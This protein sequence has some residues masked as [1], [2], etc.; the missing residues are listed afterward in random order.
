MIQPINTSFEHY[1][2]FYENNFQILSDEKTLI[3]VKHKENNDLIIMED[4]QNNDPDYQP[5]EFHGNQNKINVILKCETK[6]IILAGDNDGRVIQ[7]NMQNAQI[8]KNYGNLGVGGVLSAVMLD[9]IA[10]FGGFDDLRVIQLNQQKVFENPI[11]TALNGIYSMVFCLIKNEDLTKQPKIILSCAG[12]RSENEMEKNDLFDITK[13]I[14]KFNHKIPKTLVFSSKSDEPTFKS[15]MQ[16]KRLTQEMRKKAEKQ[17]EVKRSLAIEK[18][19]FLEIIRKEKNA[20]EWDGDESNLKVN[21]DELDSMIDEENTKLKNQLKKQK[22]EIVKLKNQLEKE[23]V[24]KS[25]IKRQHKTKVIQIEEKFNRVR[26]HLENDLEIK[27]RKNRKLIKQLK[28]KNDQF[29]KEKSELVG[30]LNRLED[31]NKMLRNEVMHL[32]LLSNSRKE[33]TSSHDTFQTESKKVVG[34]RYLLYKVI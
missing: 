4:I 7:Y 30:L 12:K 31:D 34:S 6:Q 26:T 8:I 33:C 14:K 18:K 23:K 29:F 24:E 5:L 1:S 9:N 3:G 17:F 22:V 2:T 13:L 20:N 19:I 16:I 10:V 28:E 27:R 15:E 32:K 25:E 11:E 21:L